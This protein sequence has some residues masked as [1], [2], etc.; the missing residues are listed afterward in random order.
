MLVGAQTVML[1]VRLVAD[2]EFPGLI[3]FAGALIATLL[4]YPVGIL[5]LLPQYRPEEKDENRPI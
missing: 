3:Y 1:L 5:L 4:W 2:A